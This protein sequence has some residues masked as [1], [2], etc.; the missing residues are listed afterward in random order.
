MKTTMLKSAAFLMLMAAAV[1]CRKTGT[2]KMNNADR[3]FLDRTAYAH[4]GAKEFGSMA[5][6]RGDNAMVKD[7]GRMEVSSH[8]ADLDALKKLADA[9]NYKLPS[10]MDVEHIGYKVSLET[11]TGRNFDS[12]Y[13]NIIQQDHVT[14]VGI[15]Q[16][17]IADGKDEELKTYARNYMNT[18]DAHKKNADLIITSMNIVTR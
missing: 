12:S 2:D 17:E 14:M 11:K 6:S 10:N 9:R 7:Y 1:S 5:D 4:N 8:S 3:E 16:D 15:M 13:M 18:A